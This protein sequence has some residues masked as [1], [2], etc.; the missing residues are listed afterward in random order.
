MAWGVSARR[1]KRGEGAVQ[2]KPAVILSLHKQPGANTLAL[3]Q[4]LDTTLAAIQRSLPD[5]MRLNAHIFRQ[6]DFIA[7]AIENVVDA[8]QDGVLVVVGILLL[9]LLNIRATLITL[10]A[11]PLSLGGMAIAIGALSMTPLSMPRTSFAGSERTRHCRSRRVTT[12]SA[13]RS[14]RPWRFVRPSLLPPSSLPWSL[15]RSSSSA[16]LKAACSSR[17]VWPT[18]SRCLPRSWL[19]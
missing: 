8:L 1:L 7:V 3:T 5:G 16:A 18:W 17:W 10:V 4:T 12:R 13:L 14:R 19:P 2:G 11:I 6:A 9:F 15:S